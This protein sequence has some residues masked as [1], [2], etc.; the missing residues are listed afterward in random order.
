MTAEKFLAVLPL[1][2]LA[3]PAPAQI[4]PEDNI[5]KILTAISEE[6][7][8]IDRLL[9]ESSRK[10]ASAGMARA[11]DRIK[12]LMQ[13]S[14]TSQD[15]VIDDIAQLIEEIERMQQ[16]N[17]SSRGS[18]QQSQEQQNKPGDKPE[19]QQ[20]STRE[21]TQSPE[22]VDRPQNEQSRQQDANSTQDQSQPD[23]L[24]EGQNIEATQRPED[25]TEKAQREANSARW[26]NL[27]K[28]VRFMMNRGGLP[29]VPEK[30]RRLL[31]A[32]QKQSHKRR[33]R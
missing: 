33:D 2:L 22:M 31:E 25:A 9:M 27:P 28:Y 7:T 29:E 14:Q 8:E 26:G 3:I 10:G 18:S 6:M 23:P 21:Q 11:A 15:K 20:R 5:R 13:Q 12:E 4:G 17:S 1:L 16:S 32:Y 24:N 30:Y 19:D